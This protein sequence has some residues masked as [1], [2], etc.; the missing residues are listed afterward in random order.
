MNGKA[1]KNEKKTCTQKP[2]KKSIRDSVWNEFL[3][4]MNFFE[5]SFFPV[6]ENK[7]QRSV[8]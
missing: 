5:P 7:H 3:K 2:H 8:V 6:R 1:T 4:K